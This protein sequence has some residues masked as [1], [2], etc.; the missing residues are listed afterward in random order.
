LANR[1]RDVC[2]RAYSN[3]HDVPQGLLISAT[4]LGL[5]PQRRCYQAIIRESHRRIFRFA[6]R[7]SYRR[8][9]YC[10]ACIGRTGKRHDDEACQRIKRT[11]R[12]DPSD[13]RDVGPSFMTATCNRR[14]RAARRPDVQAPH[15]PGSQPFFVPVMSRRSRTRQASPSRRNLDCLGRRLKSS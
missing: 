3:D 12:P 10:P 9:T 1:V 4:L 6:C 7:R 2:A 11:V 5:S 13:R 14:A 8:P 15:C